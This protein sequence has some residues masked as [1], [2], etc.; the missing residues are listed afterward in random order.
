MRTF[1]QALIFEFFSVDFQVF[2][3]YM[4][5]PIPI[6]Y[7]NTLI[8]KL[9]GDQF[10]GKPCHYPHFLRMSN[11]SNHAQKILIFATFCI[12]NI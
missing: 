12:S 1:Y 10:Q 3:K 11:V 4:I 8:S 6:M 5:M 2:F 9:F 7:V